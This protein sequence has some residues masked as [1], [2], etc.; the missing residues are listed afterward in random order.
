MESGLA[1][2][3]AS[4]ASSESEAAAAD[5]TTQRILDAALQVAAA[6]GTQRLTVEDVVR[7]AGVSRMTVYRRY[8]RR[9]DLLEALTQRETQRFLA[10]VAAGI[11]A[12]ADRDD[13]VTEGFI[14]VV[15]FAR[16][17]PLLRRL[18]HTEP[19]EVFEAVAAEDGRLLKT[20][21][22]F[23]ARQIHGGRPGSPSRNARWVA[24]SLARLLL[25]YIAVPPKDPD[26]DDEAQLREFAHRVLAP[27]VA[28]AGAS[29]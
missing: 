5:R 7:R 2:V 18:A 6:V 3:V 21:V 27:M 23:A 26:F 12:A 17:H 19:G 8:P 16:A 4:A 24:D 10:A 14:A 15:R 28:R 13:R 20:G 29:G 1:G 9:D 25:T 22:E 11:E